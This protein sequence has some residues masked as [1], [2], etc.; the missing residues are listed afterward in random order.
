MASSAAFRH[1]VRNVLAT[2]GIVAK[3]VSSFSLQAPRVV[4]STALSTLKQP[5]HS[6][7]DDRAACDD[8]FSFSF[9]EDTQFNHLIA[10]TGGEID[11]RRMT[12]QLERSRN[13]LRRNAVSSSNMATPG[14]SQLTNISNSSNSNDS[15]TTMYDSTSSSSLSSAPRT[16]WKGILLQYPYARNHEHLAA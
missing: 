5:K 12:E 2:E 9:A 1:Y 7:N 11:T 6:T 10:G 3:K 16:K 8:A 13:Q 15:S 14:K 4:T